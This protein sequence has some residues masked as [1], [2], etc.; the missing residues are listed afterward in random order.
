M[1]EGSLI[2]DQSK[3]HNILQDLEYSQQALFRTQL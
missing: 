1:F 3:W 2:I